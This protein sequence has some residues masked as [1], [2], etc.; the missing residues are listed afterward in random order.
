MYGYSIIVY[1]FGVKDILCLDFKHIIIYTD[2]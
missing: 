1:V 2:S